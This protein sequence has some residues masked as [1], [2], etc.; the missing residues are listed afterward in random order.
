MQEYFCKFK[1]NLD[2]FFSFLKRYV[3]NDSHTDLGLGLGVSWSIREA[4]IALA[5]AS[6]SS[7]ESTEQ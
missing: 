4:A 5:R 1:E 3:N 7:L 2:N 6:S